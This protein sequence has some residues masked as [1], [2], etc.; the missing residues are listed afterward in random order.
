MASKHYDEITRLAKQAGW[1]EAAGFL[2]F[3][4]EQARLRGK[5]RVATILHDCA[6]IVVKEMNRRDNND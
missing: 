3:M 5:T 4:A 2:I 1:L 6:E